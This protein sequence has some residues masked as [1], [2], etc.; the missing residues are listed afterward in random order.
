MKKN[1]HHRT[2]SR[3]PRSIDPI[4]ITLH[5]RT[6]ITTPELETGNR[7]YFRFPFPETQGVTHGN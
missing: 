2:A 4:T 1:Q 6:F 3:G 5:D 7:K